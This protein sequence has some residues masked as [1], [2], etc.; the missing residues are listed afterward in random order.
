MSR[1]I[2]IEKPVRRIKQFCGKD[3]PVAIIGH[4]ANRFVKGKPLTL[5]TPPKVVYQ[6]LGTLSRPALKY[7]CL[8]AEFKFNLKETT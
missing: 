8:L 4:A 1:A 3:H 5:G 7:L 6:L 2:T